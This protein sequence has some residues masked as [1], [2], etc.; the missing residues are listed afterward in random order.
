MKTRNLIASIALLALSSGFSAAA[1]LGT[2]FT[3]QGKLTDGG[4]SANGL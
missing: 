1:P 2:A 4:P 3:Y